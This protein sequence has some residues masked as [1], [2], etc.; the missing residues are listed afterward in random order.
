MNCI[1]SAILSSDILS[2]DILERLPRA[3]D[4]AGFPVPVGA[5]S[6]HQKN[7]TKYRTK[8]NDSATH[9]LNNQ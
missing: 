5:V 1:E 2:S 4:N 7:R 8:F 3:G 9:S 6:K